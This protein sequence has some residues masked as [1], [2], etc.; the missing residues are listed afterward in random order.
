MVSIKFDCRVIH[1]PIQLQ[2]CL[3]NAFKINCA[4]ICGWII[5]Y[6]EQIVQKLKRSSTKIGG[7][8]RRER[9]W[10]NM[11]YNHVLVIH[12]SFTSSLLLNHSHQPLRHHVWPRRW[13]FLRSRCFFSSTTRRST[14]SSLGSIVFE[15]KCRWHC[16][17]ISAWATE[18]AVKTES[19]LWERGNQST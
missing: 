12:Q 7:L 15:Q 6:L 16:D 14:G 13:H 11:S 17:K 19:T 18:G 2:T 10:K 4:P 3:C 9:G 1:A 5:K 8:E